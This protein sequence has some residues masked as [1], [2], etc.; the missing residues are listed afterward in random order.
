MICLGIASGPTVARA[1]REV[2]PCGV[3]LASPVGPY[4]YMYKTSMWTLSETGT[5]VNLPSAPRSRFAIGL[6]SEC[7]REA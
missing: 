7:R 2:Q 4:T 3:A 6:R 5:A 1:V